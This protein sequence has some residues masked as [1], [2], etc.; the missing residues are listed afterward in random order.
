[1]AKEKLSKDAW[2][3]AGFRSLAER[4]PSAVQI[5]L[6]AKA[7]GATKGSFYWHF[8]DITEY[9]TAMLELWRTKV[10]S[11]VIDDI[12][13]QTT[14]EERLDALFSNA[15]RPAPGDFGGQKIETA[16]RAWALSDAQVAAA[17]AELDA[18]RLAFLETLLDDQGMDG[19][20]L[21]ELIYGAYIGLDD[22]QSK[23][24]ANNVTALAALKT[25]ILQTR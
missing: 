13:A 15:T 20:V 22:L 8:K 6:L 12:A 16:M 10:A 19:A 21:S 5:N 2:L 11:E 25:M 1:M 18:L 14:P 17:L 3:A 23:G 7:V 4:G 24:R 9:K